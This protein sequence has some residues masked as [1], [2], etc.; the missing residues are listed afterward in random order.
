MG[1]PNFKKQSAGLRIKPQALSV[2]P[3]ITK[4]GKVL[5]FHGRPIYLKMNSPNDADGRQLA[6]V[7]AE[8]LE[9]FI[10]PTEGGTASPIIRPDTMIIA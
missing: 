6:R 9:R 7:L 10:D 1:L 3:L 5:G 2:A 4:D 8:R